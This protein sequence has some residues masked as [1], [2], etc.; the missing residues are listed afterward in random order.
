MRRSMRVFFG[1]LA[2]AVTLAACNNGNNSSNIPPGGGTNCGNPPYN[3]EVI[4]PKPNARRVPDN[5]GGVVVA[6]SKALPSGNQYALW[7]NQSNGQA[8]FTSNVNGGPVYGPGSGFT[9]IAY[10]KIPSPHAT[11]TFSNPQYYV[12]LFVNPLGPAQAVNLYW[13]DAG[14]G[15]NPNVIVSSFSTR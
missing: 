3:M 6:F 1:A 13:Y 8:Q 4:Y 15:C 5:N 11:P 10:S 9:T 12:T 14:L 7:V 2:A